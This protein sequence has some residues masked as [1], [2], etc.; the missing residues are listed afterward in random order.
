MDISTGLGALGHRMIAQC[1][2]S[3]SCIGIT[4][5][6]SSALLTRIAGNCQAR[7]ADLGICH[8][9]ALA[10]DSGGVSWEAPDGLKNEKRPV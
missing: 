10:H 8:E 5:P 1:C 3:S 4:G 7:S 6:C 2:S 9:C